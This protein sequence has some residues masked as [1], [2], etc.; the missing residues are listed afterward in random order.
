MHKAS[1]AGHSITLTFLIHQLF[2]YL[3]AKVKMKKRRKKISKTS[4]VQN[5]VKLH[6][7]WSISKQ[8]N[9][10]LNKTFYGGPSHRCPSIVC[11]YLSL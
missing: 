4:V 5:F 11:V 1:I 6:T 2:V 8:I 10:I 7:F 3:K 9:K